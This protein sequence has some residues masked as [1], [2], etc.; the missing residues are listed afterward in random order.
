MSEI[1]I[2]K[3]G[4]ETEGNEFQK[5]TITAWND[6]QET[7]LHVTAEEAAA[8]LDTWGTADESKA[9]ICHK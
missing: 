3:Q 2:V 5:E 7:G 1:E 4:L 6:Y 9:P 8:W